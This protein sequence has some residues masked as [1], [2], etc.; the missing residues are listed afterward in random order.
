MFT[1]EQIENIMNQCGKGSIRFRSAAQLKEKTFRNAAKSSGCPREAIIGVLDTTIF[2]SGKNCFVLTA[3]TLYR[4]EFALLSATSKVTKLSLLG[5][6]GVEYMDTRNN[7]LAVD[8]RNGSRVIIY[9]EQLYADI[10]LHI[11]ESVM[12]LEQPSEVDKS[13]SKAVS[14]TPPPA[15]SMAKADVRELVEKGRRARWDED[16]KTAF[17]L[18]NE[19]THLGDPEGTYELAWLYY[20]GKGVEWD[21]A[22][23]LTLYEKA[24]EKGL[25]QAQVRC[26]EMYENGMGTAVDKQKAFMWYKRA[27][28]QNY[29]IGQ[30]HCANMYRYGEGTEQ[31]LKKALSLYL[32]ASEEKVDG[33]AMCLGEMYEYGEGTEVD[34]E[35]ALMWYEKA[36]KE[37]NFGRARYKCGVLYDNRQK[38]PNDKEKALLWYEEAIKLGYPDAIEKIDNI[39]NKGEGGD[40]YPRDKDRVRKAL[41]EGIGF[42]RKLIT[43]VL[44]R[45]DQSPEMRQLEEKASQGDMEAQFRC[46]VM[47]SKGIGIKIDNNKALMW[48]EKAAEQGMV[49]AQFI[50]G[51]MYETGQEITQNKEKALSWY[52]KAAAQGHIDALLNSALLYDMSEKTEKN[53][54]NTHML[55]QLLISN[56]ERGSAL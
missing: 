21:K 10:V 37:V 33:S 26:G 1:H 22:K 20:N 34:L 51:Y 13:A 56:L 49:K 18:L 30:Y 41:M 42:Q 32:Q 16:Y 9:L 11:L 31:D 24:A 12:K 47:Y 19:A 36:V 48:Y 35:K 52:G 39:Y 40:L 55:Y 14:E 46:G 43:E 50:C 15:E 54:F 44:E 7:L 27:A 2:G 3:D 38:S 5:I 45:L 23:A 25:A 53:K 17:Y 28:D 29:R 8:Y 4:K 6:C